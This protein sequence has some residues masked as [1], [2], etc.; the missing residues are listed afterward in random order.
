M[1]V[2]LPTF[3]RRTIGPYMANPM[4]WRIKSAGRIRKE[5]DELVVRDRYRFRTSNEVEYMETFRNLMEIFITQV[6]KIDVKDRVVLDVGASIA[7]S[8]IYFASIGAAKVIGLEPFPATLELAKY[9]VKLNKLEGT[10]KLVNAAIGATMKTITLTKKLID[11]GSINALTF[12]SK[13]GMTVP[14]VTL[15][16]LVNKYDINNAIAKFDC[17]GAEYKAIIAAPD[18]TLHAFTDFLIEYD[19]LS[20]NELKRLDSK[21]RV[22]GFYLVGVNKATTIIHYRRIK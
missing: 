1:G 2:E 12:Q 11:T 22:A 8:P 6:Y 13:K 20:P 14:V 16:Y 17:E 21:F 10:I 18:T 7:D 4:W 5:G 3:V 19:Y 15:Q 9:N